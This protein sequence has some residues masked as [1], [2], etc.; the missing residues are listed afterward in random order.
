MNFPSCWISWVKACLSSASF[1]ILNNGKPLDWIRSHRGVRQ[2]DPISLYLFLLV[3]CNLS[4][5]LNHVLISNIILGFDR[6]LSPNFNHL[7]FAND[8]LIVT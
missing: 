5:I 7:M 8:L 1:S 6:V 2:G 3:S 4:A